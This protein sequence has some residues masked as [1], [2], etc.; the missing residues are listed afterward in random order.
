MFHRDKNIW[1]GLLAFILGLFAVA[2]AFAES[3]D[4]RSYGPLY[5]KFDLTLTPGQRTEIAGP[6]FYSQKTEDSTTWALPPFYAHVKDSGTDSEEWDFLYPVMTYDRFGT[7]HRWQFFQIF[8][9]SGGMSTRSGED[10]TKKRYEVFPFYFHQSSPIPTNVYTA[11]IPFYGHLQNKLF[12]DEIYFI[13]MPIYVQ[14]RKADVYTYNY[15]FPFFDVRY[16]NALHG[17][18]LWPLVGH[19]HKDVTLQTNSF[20][21]VSTNGGHEKLFVLWPFFHQQTL[22][23]GTVNRSFEQAL[24]PLYYL[25]RS[26]LRDQTTVIWPFFS[27]IN[28]REK[29]YRE[30]QLPFPFVDFARGSKTTDRIL[31]LFSR[32]HN[33]TL[34][35]DD[36]LWPL[37]KYNRVHSGALDRERTRIALYLYSDVR[38]K[39]LE[40]GQMLHRVD[41]FPFF[42]W[43]KDFNGNSRLQMLSILDPILPNNKSIERDWDPVY[44]FWRQEKNPRTGAS[45][46]SLFWNLYRR[47][48]TPVS[49]KCS[50]LFGLFQYQ[51]DG[52]GRRMR[53]FFIPVMKT[54]PHVPQPTP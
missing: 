30:W 18:Q 1:G 22:G 16:G 28:D 45:S 51:S 20:S 47:E 37:Y 29:K 36:Y 7:E 21:E 46:Q 53:L 23:I 50:L 12:R 38:E 41:F 35:A 48:K 19:E 11:V 8:N 5:D 31:P 2:S 44:A 43:R 3:G 54:H 4:G 13:M 33:A 10:E 40:T 42:T 26:P 14:T 17:W 24:L 27:F 15:F 32:S 39:N 9:I 52:D 25:M 49:K 6:V 34:E